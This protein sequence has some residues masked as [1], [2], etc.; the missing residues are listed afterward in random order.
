MQIP[1][2]QI[3][4]R[5][6]PGYKLTQIGEFLARL[7][8]QWSILGECFRDGYDIYIPRS[9]TTKKIATYGSEEAA[10]ELMCILSENGV[11]LGDLEECLRNIGV[12]FKTLI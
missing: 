10:I 8:D 5:D 4:L 2:K 7:T 11:T 6:I 9:E 12:Q 3:P 1:T